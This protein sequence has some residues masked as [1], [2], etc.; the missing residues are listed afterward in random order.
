MKAELTNPSQEATGSWRILVVDELALPETGATIDLMEV[1]PEGLRSRYSH[2]TSILKDQPPT[3]A[4][5]DA[6][7]ILKGVKKGHYGKIIERL[8]KAGMVVLQ[9]TPPL[10][11]NGIFG[12]AKGTKSRLIVDCRRA[13]MYF[14]EPEGVRLPSPA[15][16]ANLRINK[17]ERVYVA[18]ADM[19]DYFHNFYLPPWYAQYFGLPALSDE[20]G[21]KRYPVLRSLPMGWAHSVLLAQS[22][23]EHLLRPLSGLASRVSSISH[24]DGAAVMEYIDDH[25]FLALD[26]ITANQLL[27]QSLQLLIAAGL[28]SH[29][30]KEVWATW[31]QEDVEVL[32]IRLAKGVQIRPTRRAV[33]ALIRETTRLVKDKTVRTN[34]LSSLAGKWVWVLMIRRPFLAFLE[35]IYVVLKEA[36]KDG[37]KSVQNTSKLRGEL[38]N[39]LRVLPLVEFSLERKFAKQVLASDASEGG[40]GVVSTE[41]EEPERLFRFRVRKGWASFLTGKGPEG[42]DGELERE[43]GH[44]EAHDFLKQKP[45]KVELSFAWRFKDHIVYLETRAI[46]QAIQR[47]ISHIRVRETSTRATTLFIFVDARAALGA[48]A[49]GRSSS[50][51]LNVI[52][53]RIAIVCAVADIEM[54][55]IWAPTDINPADNPSRNYRRAGAP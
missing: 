40:C 38:N 6:I 35:E 34:T 36:A 43:I 8:V 3:S 48:C 9:D 41:T 17:G 44:K 11:I 15:D 50:R 24:L 53:R 42:Y 23:H 45:W 52:L 22:A 47:F 28:S 25:A 27:W 21:E 19:K 51:R 13:N 30:G 39:L 26:P 20:Q 5:L 12:V 2:P 29:P 16:L 54:L 33:K 37:R 55:Y 18:K 10:C 31:N 46:L 32:G 1:L 49:K 14:R 4:A 7:P